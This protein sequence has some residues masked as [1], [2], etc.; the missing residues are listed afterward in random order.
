MQ[1]NMDDYIDLTYFVDL[2]WKT[3]CKTAYCRICKENEVEVLQYGYQRGWLEAQDMCTGQKKPERR[4]VARIVHQFI[5]IEL[6][7]ADEP[8]WNEAKQLLDLYDCRV[9]VNHVAQIFCK[10]IMKEREIHG[11]KKVFG[12]RE[13]LTQAEAKEIIDNIFYRKEHRTFLKK[14]EIPTSGAIKLSSEEALTHK[15]GILIDVRTEGEY[16]SGYLPGAKHCSMSQILEGRFP[17]PDQKREYCL[18]CEQGYQSE[19]AANYLWDQGYQYVYYFGNQMK[20][21]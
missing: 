19:I 6:M 1:E 17:Y 7:E 2:L 13:L 15:K 14:T 9:C 20:E 18:Y 12:M 16:E 4:D 21:T 11:D 10:G 3:Y 5:K 8:E